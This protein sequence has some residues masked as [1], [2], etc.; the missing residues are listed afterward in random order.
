MSFSYEIRKRDPRARVRFAIGD[1][2]P[3]TARFQDEEIEVLL[4]NAAR[5]HFLWLYLDAEAEV[6]EDVTGAKVEV[7]VGDEAVELTLSR[8]T[9]VD[10]YTDLVIDDTDN[11]TVTSAARPFVDADAGRTLVVEES[12]GFTAGTYTVSSVNAGAATLSAAVGD[13]SATGG[14]AELR[15]WAPVTLP[16]AG[17]LEYDTI[18]ELIAAIN[19][20][21]LG[22][23]VGLDDGAFVLWLMGNGERQEEIPASR[24]QLVLDAP[25]MDLALT[26]E[27]NVYGVAKKKR[28]SVYDVEAAT[29][30]A[31]VLRQTGVNDFKELRDGNMTRVRFGPPSAGSTGSAGPAASYSSW[32]RW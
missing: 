22:W 30:R 11:T 18:G 1:T 7:E 6:N 25:S 9:L 21:A 12:T 4:D 27:L 10:T 2:T 16:L 24:Y 3:A 20:L 8:L 31:N 26:G 23:V 14:G 5:K 17:S 13:L 32:R 29:A 15:E 28:L 19:A